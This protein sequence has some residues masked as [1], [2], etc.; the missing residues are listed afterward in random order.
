MRFSP[1]IPPLRPDASRRAAAA[2]VLGARNGCMRPTVTTRVECVEPTVFVSRV[3]ARVYRVPRDVC[4][5]PCI[6]LQR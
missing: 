4:G 5:C 2:L 6:R 3:S 1:P